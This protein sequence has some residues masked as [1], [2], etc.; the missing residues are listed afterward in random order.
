MSGRFDGLPLGCVEEE[1]YEPGLLG[2]DEGLVG[3]VLRWFAANGIRETSD[4]PSSFGKNLAGLA[5][6]VNDIPQGFNCQE[7]LDRVVSRLTLSGGDI[8]TINAL[9]SP[10]IQHLYNRG[11]TSLDIDISSFDLCGADHYWHMLGN[12]HGTEGSP[13]EVSLKAENDIYHS[14]FSCSYCGFTISGDVYVLG[15]DASHCEFTFTPKGRLATINRETYPSVGGGSFE[16]VSPCI[17]GNEARHCTF[18]LLGY[19]DA[20]MLDRDD[21]YDEISIR[22]SR[23]D[24]TNDLCRL[25]WNLFEEGDTLLVPDGAGQWKE[26]RGK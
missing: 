7:F 2:F 10:L 3:E 14:G 25:G 22:L 4:S 13:L 1:S 12:L 21:S 15:L 8:F 9:V 24:G 19:A 26:V 16:M 23:E 11:R 5:A 18:R 17:I 6:I 20:V